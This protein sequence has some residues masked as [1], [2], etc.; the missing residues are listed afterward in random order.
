MKVIPT[1]SNQCILQGATIVYA[2]LYM[3]NI[4]KQVILTFSSSLDYIYATNYITYKYID[5]GMFMFSY[6]IMRLSDYTVYIHVM[7]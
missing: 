6:I 3:Y 1:I 4:W 5:F 2:C 7:A